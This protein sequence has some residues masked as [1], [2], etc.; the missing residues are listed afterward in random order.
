MASALE[1]GRRALLRET[2]SM[3]WVC[4]SRR[5]T[6]DPAGLSGGQCQ[7]V[8]IARALASEPKLIV[9]DEPTSALDI[10]A[11]AQIL[12]LLMRLR[13]T[14][15]LALVLISHDLSVIRHMTDEAIVMRH[16]EVVEAGDSEG[17]F[18]SPPAAVHEGLD[19]GNADAARH[20]VM[21]TPPS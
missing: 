7:R 18:T 2:F 15:G 11:Q 17:I 10:S 13:A 12:N 6:A 16:G 8:G 3:R 20:S 4:R 9:A 14:H 19:G 21:M 5:W 1:E